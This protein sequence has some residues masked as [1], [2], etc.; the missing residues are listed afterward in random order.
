MTNIVINP[1]SGAVSGAT[2]E[3]AI[4]NMKHFL[5]DCNIG[6]NYKFARFP[7]YDQDDGRFSFM[8]YESGGI[9][10]IHH[11]V[12]MPGLPLDKVR[13]MGTDQNP[14]H[15]PRLYVDGSSWLWSFALL[16]TKDF[17]IPEHE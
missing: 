5:V 4:E 3:N 16:E 15:Y 11:W 1:G 2:E 13:Y 14:W 12:D 9:R 8:V 10:G 6:A 17:E 7:E